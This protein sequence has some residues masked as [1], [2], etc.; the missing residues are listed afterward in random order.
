M[1]DPE[2]Y[3]IDA[4]QVHPKPV[5]DACS[6]RTACSKCGKSVKFFCYRCGVP[7][8]ELEGEIPCIRLPFRLSV[9]KH[10]GELD[11]KSTALH[12]KIVAPNDVEIITYS[13]DCLEGAD[14]ERM[15]LLFPGP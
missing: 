9:V 6:K 13:A 3:D 12:A 2:P 11:G 14:V 4:L 10:A 8:P 15:A 1:A 7:V 5:L